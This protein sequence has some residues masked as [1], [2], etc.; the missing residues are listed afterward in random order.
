VDQSKAVSKLLKQ[1]QGNL[2]I[3]EFL[4][5]LAEM[6]EIGFQKKTWRTQNN[7][8]LQVHSKQT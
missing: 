6:A 5:K 2:G 1:K 4:N 3:Q 7:A 8:V